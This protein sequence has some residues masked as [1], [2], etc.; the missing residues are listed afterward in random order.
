MKVHLIN[1]SALAFGV[2]VI[3]PRWR[4]V[5]AAATPESYGDPVI[6]D[7][8]L[9]PW[10]PTTESAGD[11]VGIGIHTGNAVQGYAIGKVARERGAYV[12]FGGIH[13]TL[14]P[15]ESTALGAAHAVVKG[16]GDLV[17]AKVIEDC[18][19]NAPLPMY[20]G[21]KVEGGDFKAARW[22]LIP[23]DKYM[24]ASVQT[25]RGCPKHCSFCSVWRTDGQRPRQ[26]TVDAVIDEIV[27]LRRTGFRFIALADDNFYPVTLE[28][29][30]EDG[31][32]FTPRDGERLVHRPRAPHD[33]AWPSGTSTS[34]FALLRLHELTGRDRYRDRAEHVFRMYGAAAAKNPFGFAHLLAAQDFAQRGPLEIILAG[35]KLGAAA[36]VE[37]VHR[38][39]LPTRVLA[40]AEDVPIGEG[41]HPV[42]GQPAAYVCQNRTCDAPV[43]S[44]KALLERCAA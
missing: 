27:E 35:D 1:P 12:V 3:T 30:W 40:F 21:G 24:W 13:A 28:K 11:V 42:D 32:Y 25:V 17:W 33:N 22:S 34:V 23:R 8:T 18:T 36:L 15:E 2:G 19:R 9:E 41:R 20:Y 14:Y 31:L 16:D 4:Y 5:L 44:V 7:E 37:S 26:R 43:T 39:Y 6:T 29:F 10:D 38:A